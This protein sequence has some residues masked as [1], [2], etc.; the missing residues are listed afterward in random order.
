MDSEGNADLTF[1]WNNKKLDIETFAKSSATGNP[2]T[3]QK[4]KDS[5][6]ESLYTFAN[7]NMMNTMNETTKYVELNTWWRTLYKTLEFVSLAGVVL[8]LSGYC[9]ASL[10]G[11][12]KQELYLHL[13]HLQMYTHYSILIR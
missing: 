12:K 5:I 7:S 6:H 2:I 9:Y 13:Y 8:C 1:L 4:I 10:K 11:K 3:N